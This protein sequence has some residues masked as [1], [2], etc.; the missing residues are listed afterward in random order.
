MENN[1]TSF[2]FIT[3]NETVLAECDTHGLNFDS[4]PQEDWDWLYDAAEEDFGEAV[5]AAV[6]LADYHG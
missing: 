4:I 6:G 5:L 3:F 2:D 1:T